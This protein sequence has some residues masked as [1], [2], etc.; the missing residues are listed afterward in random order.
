MSDSSFAV[1]A[2]PFVC[3]GTAACFASAV[4]HPIDLVKVRMQL[5]GQGSKAAIPSPF[6]IA[7]QI[8]KAEGPGGLYSGL[9]AAMTRQATYGTARIGLHRVFSQKLVD[10]NNGKPIAFYQ[11]ALSGM[12]SG[13]IAVCIGTPF[14]TA[15]VRMQNDGS[16]PAAER[17]NYKH[18]FDAFSRVAKEEGVASLWR[19]LAPNILRGMS[20][21][22]GMMACYDQSKEV[23]MKLTGDSDPKNPRLSTK[24]GAA[25]VAGFCCAFLSL[26]FDLVKSRLMSMKVNP[27]T[28]LAPYKGVADCFS[29]VLAKEGPLAFWKGFSAYY[30]RCAPHAMIILLSIESVTAFYRKTFLGEDSESEAQAEKAMVESARVIGMLQTPSSRVSGAGLKTSFFHLQKKNEMLEDEVRQLRDQL[31]SKLKQLDSAKLADGSVFDVGTPVVA[32]S[33]SHWGHYKEG[34]TGVIVNLS[35]TD[36]SDP[37]VKWDHSGEVFQ[38]SRVKIQRSGGLTLSD[39]FESM[40]GLRVVALKSSAWGHYQEGSTGVIVRNNATDPVVRWDHTGEEYQTNRL[41]LSATVD[42]IVEEAVAKK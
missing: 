30:G 18:V 32:L 24:L 36:S 41:K 1:K 38:T 19:G 42:N 9:S 21:N 8:V 16:L 3:G 10:Y 6:A 37:L 34:Q 14:D 5:L 27:A 26:P 17:R 28:G 35:P 39:G 22:M 2:Q 29:Q 4:I 31:D 20:M 15:L 11:K 7:Q 40:E 33:S 25:A 23:V 13:A 12:G